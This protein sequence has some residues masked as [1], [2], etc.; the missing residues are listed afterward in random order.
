MDQIKDE[1]SL[2][3]KGGDTITINNKD[4]IW[5]NINAS[6]NYFDFNVIL[7]S[8]ND[9][10][11]GYMV[12]YIECEEDIP[13]VTMA[14]GSNDQGRIFFNGVDIYAFVDARPLEIDADKGRV[15]LKKGLNVIIFKI[16][17]EQNSWQGSMRLMDKAGVPLKDLKIKLSP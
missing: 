3:P 13:D 15:T 11:A 4:L 2:K 9:R 6:T 14:V 12:T 5:K 10:A 7:D 17:N 16:I 8:L 1:A